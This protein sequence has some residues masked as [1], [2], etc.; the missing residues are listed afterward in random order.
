MDFEDYK[1]AMD[2]KLKETFVDD[3]GEQKPK[4]VGCRDKDLKNQWERIK[5]MVEEGKQH[6]YI[7]EGDAKLMIPEKPIPGRLYG[8]VKDHKPVLLAAIY[9]NLG[10]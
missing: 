7:S 10:R 2:E 4:Y 1:P 9:L 6:G 5:K 3:S 8:L